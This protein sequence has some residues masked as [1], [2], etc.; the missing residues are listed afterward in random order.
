MPTFE[1]LQKA[2]KNGGTIYDPNR[3]KLIQTN[4]W[5]TSIRKAAEM[6]GIRG[7][8]RI[9]LY[10]HQIADTFVLFMWQTA[11]GETTDVP[12]MLELLVLAGP[13]GHT[14]YNSVNRGLLKLGPTPDMDYVLRR[15]APASAHAAAF[16]K[17]QEAEDNAANHKIHADN[18]ARETVAREVGRHNDAA[19]A[20]IRGGAI[21]IASGD[22]HD[23]T[24]L[25]NLPTGRRHSVLVEKKG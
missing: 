24:I 1:Q 11:P 3:H 19:A 15:L 17:R 16:R 23:D 10:H 13:P 8:E 12:V 5:V 4:D 22:E 9:N 6:N 14:T 25:R 21:P 20:A 18:E 2:Q 7:W